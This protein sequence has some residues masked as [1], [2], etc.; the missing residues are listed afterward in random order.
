MATDRAIV[1]FRSQACMQSPRIRQSVTLPDLSV[2]LTTNL[3]D[4]LMAIGIL[5]LRMMTDEN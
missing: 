3:M 4:M 1:K 2:L 5:P